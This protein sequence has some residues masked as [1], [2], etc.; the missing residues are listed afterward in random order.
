MR[1]GDISSSYAAGGGANLSHRRRGQSTT[2]Y[3]LLVALLAIVGTAALA[4]IVL[5]L[6]LAAR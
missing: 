3:S 5:M 2:E 1:T 6:R 4:F